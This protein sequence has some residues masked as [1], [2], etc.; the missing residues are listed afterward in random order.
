MNFFKVYNAYERF[1]FYEIPK[2]GDDTC[3]LP[4]VEI[5]SSELVEDQMSLKP[6]LLITAGL[7][8][9]D[10]VA[11]SVAMNFLHYVGKSQSLRKLIGRV[12][13]HGRPG[14]APARA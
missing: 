5:G 13:L 10:D 12:E 7:G 2:C 4:V 6:K 11:I 14:S 8:G 3:Q 1:E 9:T